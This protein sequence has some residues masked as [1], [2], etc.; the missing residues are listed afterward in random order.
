MADVPEQDKLRSELV[1]TCGYK[2]STT[3]LPACNADAVHSLSLATRLR[4]GMHAGS[5]KLASQCDRH[6][7]LPPSH[8]VLRDHTQ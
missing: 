7:S 3:P 8:L 1:A 5:G 6:Q 4:P 2:N